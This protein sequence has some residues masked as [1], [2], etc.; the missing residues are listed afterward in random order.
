MG[1][2][3]YPCDAIIA[4]SKDRLI[5]IVAGIEALEKQV[6][7]EFEKARVEFEKARGGFEAKIEM[8]RRVREKISANGSSPAPAPERLWSPHS[9]DD[10]V[11]VEQT[12]IGRI[13]NLTRRALKRI[14]SEMKH[15]QTTATHDSAS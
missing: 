5:D 9:E 3:S 7:D 13:E 12:L 6:R 10:R 2:L 14:L 11:S 1:L 4:P 8:L 15:D